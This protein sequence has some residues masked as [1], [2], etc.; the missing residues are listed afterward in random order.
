M[1]NLPHATKEIDEKARRYLEWPDGCRA[2]EYAAIVSLEG[3]VVPEEEQ[4]L[5]YVY[6]DEEFNDWVTEVRETLANKEKLNIAIAQYCKDAEDF[7]AEIAAEQEWRVELDDFKRLFSPW[8][9]PDV[10]IEL[11]QLQNKR[12]D[13]L[14]QF[15]LSSE[16]NG[17]KDEERL[18]DAELARHFIIFGCCDANYFAYW[19]ISNELAHCPIVLISHEVEGSTVMADNIEQF[20]QLVAAGDRWVLNYSDDDVNGIKEELRGEW[21]MRLIFWKAHR[22]CKKLGRWLS[23]NYKIKPT[24]TPQKLVDDAIARHGDIERWLLD[25]AI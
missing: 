20:L 12:E 2:Y 25:R 23:R 8:S 17:D 13:Y 15:Y 5:H 7:A 11:A 9:V 18:L 21:L 16:G 3:Y 1:E 22:K 4:F 14:T 24:K 19:K 10:L 6:E